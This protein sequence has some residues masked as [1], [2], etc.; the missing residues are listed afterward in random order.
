[1]K[2]A[3][4]CLATIVGGVIF[5]ILAMYAVVIP[6]ALVVRT[7]EAATGSSVN[8]FITPLGWLLTIVMIGGIIFY[9]VTAFIAMFGGMWVT[10]HVEHTNR[11]ADDERMNP[12]K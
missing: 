3:L 8:A 1:M 2:D 4:G 6:I 11:Y 10:R 12:L 5:G 9:V 7:G